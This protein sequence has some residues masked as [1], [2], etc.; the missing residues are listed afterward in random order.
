MAICVTDTKTSDCR[1]ALFCPSTYSELCYH[2][3][4]LIMFRQNYHY[5]YS[6]LL[7]NLRSR[8][9]YLLGKVKWWTWSH[10]EVSNVFFAVSSSVSFA[11]TSIY[12]VSAC[13]ICFDAIFEKC[14]GYN[15]KGKTTTMVWY[16]KL[17]C[18]SHPCYAQARNGKAVTLSSTQDLIL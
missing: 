13:K 10:F 11:N 17:S 8:S 2:G 7:D 3:I 1:T 15:F 9:S 12:G 5:G 6:S 18:T 4:K 16:A 14:R